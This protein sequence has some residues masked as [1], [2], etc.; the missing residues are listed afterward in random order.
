MALL[1]TPPEQLLSETVLYASPISVIVCF[2]GFYFMFKL[3]RR[4]EYNLPPSPPKLPLIGHLH[5][6][7]TLPHHSLT[8]LS[9]KY[10]PIMLLH[11]GQTPTLVL[12]SADLVREMV[13]T[14]DTVFSSRP[15]TTAIKIVFYGGKDVAFAPYGEEWREKRKICVLELLSQ[16]RV[17]SFQS[18]RE[19]EVADLA[20]KIREACASNDGCCVN[21]SEMIIATLSNIICRSSLG[22]KYCTSDGNSKIAK[23]ARKA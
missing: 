14:H 3:K 11:L 21:L 20:N 8:A 1:A 10:G 18:I 12:S 4:I 15:L 19:E 2:I 17:Q 22:H 16:K 7:G 13:K 5:Q 9:K 23:L 6:L